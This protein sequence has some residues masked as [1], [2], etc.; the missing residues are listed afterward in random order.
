MYTFLE[1]GLITFQDDRAQT[2]PWG[3]NGG[4]YGQSSYKTLLRVT[5]E[6][7]SLPSK[8]ENVRVHKG[9]RLMFATAGAG[10]QGDPL[11]R[12]P[13]R[14]AK[15]VR[16]GLV[17]VDAAR[18][19]YGVV[20]GADGEADDAAT[21]AERERQRGSR[22]PRPDFDFGPLPELEELR[23]RIADERR[24]FEAAMAEDATS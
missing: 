20:L 22:E 10:G 4:K 8:V 1:D 2:Y 23:T 24:E 5:G 15:D 17:T 6:E 7:W 14:V 13:E 16:A 3:V 11:D 18:D 19:D 21:T 12:E 9:D